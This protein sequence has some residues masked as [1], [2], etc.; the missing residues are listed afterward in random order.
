MISGLE[1]FLKNPNL[2]CITSS[3]KKNEIIVG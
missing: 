1:D 3:N 2:A